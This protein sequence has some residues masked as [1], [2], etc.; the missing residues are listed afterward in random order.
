MSGWVRR[1]VRRR[2]RR[3]RWGR[4]NR[5]WRC[6]KRFALMAAV[7]GGSLVAFLVMVHAL[8]VLVASFVR[9]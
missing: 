2:W 1:R 3:E 8:W 9:D 6:L 7:Y 4:W 5:H